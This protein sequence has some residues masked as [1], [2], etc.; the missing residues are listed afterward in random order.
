MS[1][2]LLREVSRVWSAGK[3]VWEETE[4]PRKLLSS[5][6][7]S[8]SSSDQTNRRLQLEADCL[9]KEEEEDSLERRRF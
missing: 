7:S 3:E 5:P 4:S 8:S 6:S 2:S 9:E 1:A